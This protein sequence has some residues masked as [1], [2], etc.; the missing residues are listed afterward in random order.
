MSEVVFKKGDKIRVYDSAWKSGVGEIELNFDELKSNDFMKVLSPF[1]MISVHTK[2]CEL[3]ERP[4]QKV[5]LYQYAWK[6]KGFYKCTIQ[7]FKDD[8]A[9][10]KWVSNLPFH[11]VDSLKYFKRLDH[12]M[13]EVDDESPN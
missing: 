9:F 5:K 11:L 2:Q 6:N 3:I 10:K 12:T 7:Y 1:G 13:I 4:K 8:E